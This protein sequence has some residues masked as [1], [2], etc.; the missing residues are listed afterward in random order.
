[1]FASHLSAALWCEKHYRLHSIWCTELIQE[2]LLLLPKH[3]N[4]GSDSTTCKYIIQCNSKKG[5]P[6]NTNLDK[7]RPSRISELK[8][9]LGFSGLPGTGVKAASLLQSQLGPES[10][11]PHKTRNRGELPFQNWERRGK[12]PVYLRVQQGGVQWVGK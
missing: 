3:R 9:V 7:L 5:T 12:P 1:M 2:D 4:P 8:I 6:L 11:T 10:Q